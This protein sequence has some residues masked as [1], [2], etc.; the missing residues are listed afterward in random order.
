MDHV[1]PTDHPAPARLVDASWLRAHLDDPC[2][3]V[4]EVGADAT[5]Y[6]D[7]HIPCAV[8]LA[9]LDEL[10]DQDRRGLPTQERLERLLR[11][12]GT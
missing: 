7:G 1:D 10:N 2:L 4:V 5:A 11:H 6:Y 3:R 12:K 8:A 9:W